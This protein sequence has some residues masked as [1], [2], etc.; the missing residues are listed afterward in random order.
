MSSV[1]CGVLIDNTHGNYSQEELV[2]ELAAFAGKLRYG[3]NGLPLVKIPAAYYRMLDDDPGNE[4]LPQ[5]GFEVEVEL[6][7]KIN[8]LLPIGLALTVG[9]VEPGLYLI[10]EVEEE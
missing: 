3:L 6:V 1:E 5:I 8:D 10:E 2:R 7:S 9:E 4:D